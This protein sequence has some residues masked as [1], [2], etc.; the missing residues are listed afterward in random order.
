MKLTLEHGHP[1]MSLLTRAANVLFHDATD[2]QYQILLINM[3][4]YLATAVDNEV[5]SYMV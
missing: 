2:L 3:I 5:D 1:Q 4:G